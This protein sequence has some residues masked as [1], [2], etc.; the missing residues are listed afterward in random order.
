MSMN[1]ALTRRLGAF[2]LLVS[3]GLT[4]SACILAPGKFVSSLDL[5]KNGTFAFAY[6]GEISMLGLAQI[7]AMN[8]AK[9]AEQFTPAPCFPEGDSASDVPQAGAKAAAETVTS[10]ERPCTERELAQQKRDWE[11]QRA[12]SAAKEKKEL[13]QM[14]A[15][16]GGL[17]PTDPK[18]IEEFAARLRRQTGWNAVAY[19]GDGL[20]DVDY[21]L[22][23]K[24]DHDFVF[25]I[26]ERFP[27]MN[28]FVQILRRS[29]GTVRIDAPG[30]AMS[31]SS[32]PMMEML[33]MRMM[34]GSG[35]DQNMPRFAQI[36][37]SFALT[38]DGHILANNTDE[39]PKADQQG[40]KL[41]WAVNARTAS[42]PTALVRLGN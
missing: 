18:S 36:D 24:L 5:R 26:I 22:S 35:A 27:T 29:D 2:A 20:F 14:K 16:F 6:K 42:A 9:A 8:K 28:T 30:F 11:E 23:G 17:D 4:L 12:L 39:G 38:T 1:Q 31:Q 10:G 37:G 7:A 40:Q 32:N 19:K 13:D 33:G 3:L 25:P 21:A 41:T 15:A 34:G